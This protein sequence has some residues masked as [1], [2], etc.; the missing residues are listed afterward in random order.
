MVPGP[1]EI[2]IILLVAGAVLAGLTFLMK[3]SRN[4]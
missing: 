3:R 1:F 4:K 2:L